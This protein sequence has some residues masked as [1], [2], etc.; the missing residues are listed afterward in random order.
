MA[1]AQKRQAA[2]GLT[3][4]SG[5]RLIAYWWSQRGRHWRGWHETLTALLQ[6]GLQPSVSSLRKRLTEK[7]ARIVM[8]AV[9]AAAADLERLA[10]KSKPQNFTEKQSTKDAKLM[11][12]RFMAG[13]LTSLIPPIPKMPPKLPIPPEKVPRPTVLRP[14]AGLSKGAL[15]LLAAVLLLKLRD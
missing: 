12:Q 6:S 14:P 13:D 8:K 1:R 5:A 11:V 4:L 2:K 3:G 15:L 10:P 9:N 7:Q